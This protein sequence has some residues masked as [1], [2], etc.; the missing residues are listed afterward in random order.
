MC[1]KVSLSHDK[2]SKRRKPNLS[3]VQLSISTNV[4]FKTRNLASAWQKDQR[5][6]PSIRLYRNFFRQIYDSLESSGTFL[7]NSYLQ[8]WQKI[9]FN[10]V[11]YYFVPFLRSHLTPR[12]SDGTCESQR[13]LNRLFR[14]PFFESATWFLVII[15]KFNL[16]PIF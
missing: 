10:E 8:N 9:H 5:S 7:K 11:Y 13:L 14:G 2:I 3:P 12:L 16:T 6:K 1:Q 15:L 4:L